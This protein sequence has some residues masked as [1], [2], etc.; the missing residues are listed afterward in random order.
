MI[1]F[2]K[3]YNKKLRNNDEKIGEVSVEIKNDIGINNYHLGE[4]N[5]HL[6]KIHL[7]FK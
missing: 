3:K 4:N 5:I 6:G 1:K 2:L 7:H